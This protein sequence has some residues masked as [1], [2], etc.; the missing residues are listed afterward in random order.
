VVGKHRELR[1]LHIVSEVEN[2]PDEAQAL[3]VGG[4]I[5]ALLWLQGAAVEPHGFQLAVLLLL[6]QS[7]AQLGIARIEVDGEGRSAAG[8]R[9]DRRMN[10]RVA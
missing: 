2:G 1:A 3:L 10:Q 5:V 4:R 7:E 8:E 9:Q 6:E